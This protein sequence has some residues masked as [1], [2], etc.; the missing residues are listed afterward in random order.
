[1]S[2][3][4]MF[5]TSPKLKGGKIKEFDVRVRVPQWFDLSLLLFIIVLEELRLR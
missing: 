4:K 2:L 5:T 1:M 3:I